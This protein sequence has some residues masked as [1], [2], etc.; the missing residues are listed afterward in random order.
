MGYRLNGQSML[1][2][3][4][5]GAGVGWGTL[6]TKTPKKK[7]E[8]LKLS[9]RPVDTSR[10]YKKSRNLS[11]TCHELTTNADLQFIIPLAIGEVQGTVP[12]NRSNMCLNLA[13]L[14]RFMIPKATPLSFRSL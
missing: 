7:D 6:Y 9:I 3:R 5:S 8:S 1:N 2:D 14:E 10:G 4:K 12:V 13:S 11:P